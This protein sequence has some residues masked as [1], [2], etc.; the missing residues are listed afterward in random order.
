MGNQRLLYRHNEDLTALFELLA[1]GKIKPAIERRMNLTEAAA[2]H[3]LIEQANVQGRIV[4]MIN[5][6]QYQTISPARPTS[7]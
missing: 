2:A 6:N 7:L 5:E 3:K 4:L 1:Q